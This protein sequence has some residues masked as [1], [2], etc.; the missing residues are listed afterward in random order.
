MKKENKIPICPVCSKPPWS[1]TDRNYLRIYGHCWSCDK[2]KWEKGKLSLKE[3]EERE[4][5]AWKNN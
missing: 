5:R 4:N 3:F 1:I 2:R